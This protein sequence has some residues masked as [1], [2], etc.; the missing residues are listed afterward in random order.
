MPTAAAQPGEARSS[1]WIAV[2]NPSAGRG[3]AGARWPALARALAAARLEVE[4]ILTSAPGDA[5]RRVAEH[6]EGGAR[7]FLAVGG[8][9]T[10]H[11]VA[12]AILA[13]GTRCTLAAA[14]LGTGNDWAR[15]LGV[16]G[17]ERSIAR[18]LATGHR[19][20]LDAGRIEHST[21]GGTATRYFVNVAGAGYDAWVIERLPAGAPHGLAY[22]AGLLRGLWRYE[23]AAYEVDGA[24]GEFRVRAP[25]FAAFAAI[26]PYCGGGMRFAPAADFADGLLELV[27]VPHLGPF[28]VLRRLPRVYGGRLHEDPMVKFA[29]APAVTIRATPAVRVEADGQLLGHTPARIEILRGAIDAIVPTSETAR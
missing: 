25:L 20:A 8:D 23:A 9:G 14:P 6:V 19:R 3:R 4:T 18:M 16:R 24:A 5:E 26:G 27:A 22:F 17:D 13:S 15:G 1:R 21:P 29:R 12:N 2:V 10:V 7:Q 28:A 11:E